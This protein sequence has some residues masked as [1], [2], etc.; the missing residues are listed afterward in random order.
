ML[1]LATDSR[2]A[3]D[4]DG[5]GATVR[6]TLH[7]EEWA[8][9]YGLME[10]ARRLAVGLRRK[11]ADL[12]LAT[13]PLQGHT[14]SRAL[15]T[16]L[17]GLPT[18]GPSPFHLWTT[19]L[20]LFEG[21][22]DAMLT[23][24]Q[25]NQ[26]NIATWYWE[27]AELPAHFVRQLDRVD[28][29]WV[30][31]RFVYR[32]FRRH[33]SRPMQIVPPV[34]P[35]FDA[36]APRAQ[37]RER[38]AIPRDAVVFLVSFDYQSSIARKNPLAAVEAF[39]RAFDPTQRGSAVQL[40]VKAHHL[41]KNPRMGVLVDDAVRAVDGLLLDEHMPA[42]DFGDLMHACDIYVSLHRAEGFGL[43][44]AEAMAI[45]KPT[46]ATAYS[47]NLDF[48]TSANSCL[49]GYQLVPIDRGDHILNNDDL[50]RT[51]DEGLWWAEPD[52][53]Q[54]V[55]W[56]RLL[57]RDTAL[58]DSLGARAASDIANIA[59]ESRV[60]DFALARL[61]ELHQQ[62]WSADLGLQTGP[63]RREPP[64]VERR[65]VAAPVPTTPPPSNPSSPLAAGVLVDGLWAPPGRLR[66]GIVVAGYLESSH[67]VGEASRS[68]LAAVRRAHVD[69]T[70][71]VLRID[72]RAVSSDNDRRGPANLNTNIIVV[73][74]DELASLHDRLDTNF[75][76]GR[77]NIGLWSWELETLPAY[78]ADASTMLDEIWANSDF[79]A[80]VLRRQVTVPV[81]TFPFPVRRPEPGELPSLALNLEDRPVF[82]F[83]FD[84][85]SVTERKNPLGLLHAFTRAF[86]PDEG[87]LLVLKSVGGNHRAIDREHVRVA[88]SQR[89]DVIVI[90]QHLPRTQLDALIARADCYASLHRSEGFGFTI[91]EA[92]AS[93]KPTIATAY[94]GNLDFM[95]DSNSFLVPYILEDVP[96]G[97]DPYP[98]NARW[99]SPDLAEGARLMR[100]VVE[101][102]AL[103]RERGD[104]AA[105]DIARTHGVDRAADFVR[106][107]FDAAQS[108]TDAN[109]TRDAG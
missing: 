93:G 36:T 68:A 20:N 83:I 34:V 13:M 94:S 77:R 90:E 103:A 31:T 66:P 28:E 21:V 62:R 48:M 57:A 99:A 109:P 72:P 6:C 39:A 98:A 49:V 84:Y 95:N 19:N 85:R 59:S 50:R 8:G 107:R 37:L 54:A 22:D 18:E 14:T 1:R 2:S 17:R 88:A 102:P 81:Y 70:A 105:R 33:T 51:Y 10:A 9:E 91:A 75:F 76:R 86:A 38:L 100:L 3:V 35:R 108:N 106:R 92:M 41:D 24:Y 27:L 97:C 15:P 56:M 12:A 78:I 89:P 53:D 5:D 101:Q 29:I 40:V 47:G 60:C 7:A 44:L 16:E 32:S 64:P 30:P 69:H 87:P 79:T 55:E 26:Y 80:S 104:Q 43:G 65:P 73:N 46:I 71:A 96:R 61:R 45:G 11:G 4:G 58:R 23:S 63:D 25:T 52:V 42:A 74:A 67:G 82:L